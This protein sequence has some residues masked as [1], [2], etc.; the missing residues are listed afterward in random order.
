MEMPEITITEAYNL[1]QLKIAELERIV[2]A[3]KAENEELKALNKGLQTDL[4]DGREYIEQLKS[5]L[6]K[7]KAGLRFY[8]DEEHITTRLSLDK[9]TT[10]Y[11]SK[12]KYW[13]Y[14]DMLFEQG[15]RARTT[16]EEIK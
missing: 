16:L 12:G 9:K 3:L 2:E 4:D 15:K 14:H 13:A 5:N 6:E 11:E 7:A 8:G 1:S 10:S